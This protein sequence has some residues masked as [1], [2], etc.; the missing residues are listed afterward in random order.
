MGVIEELRALDH[1]VDRLA[2]KYP[3]VPRQHIE[4]LVEQEHRSL[5][6]GRVRDYVPILVEHAVKDRLRH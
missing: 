2:E 1:V 5:D 6:T 4:D 3:A